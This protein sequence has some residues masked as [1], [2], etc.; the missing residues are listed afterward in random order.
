MKANSPAFLLTSISASLATCAL[1][2]RAQQPPAV[3]EIIVT[4]RKQPEPILDVPVIESV[5]SRRTLER[6]QT[7]DLKDVASLA[8]GL[9][10]GD[11]VLAIGTQVSLR[12]IG[13]TTQDTGNDQ[14]VVLD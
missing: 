6:L 1:P 3:S 7:S 9:V 10:I 4:A 13:T 5:L 14:S 11:S 12:G 8:P 2:A